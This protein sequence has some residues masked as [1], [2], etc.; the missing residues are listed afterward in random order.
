[1]ALSSTTCLNTYTGNGATSVYAYSF[2]IFDKTHLELVVYATDGTEYSPAVDTDY[3]VS[4]VDS[5]TGGNVTLVYT[6]QAYLN[7]DA[8]LKSGYVLVIRRVLPLKQETDI[9]NQGSY[10]PETHE[11]QFDRFTM[12]DQQQ[13]AEL[14]RTPKIPA[15]ETS[16]GALPSVTDRASKFAAYDSSGDPIA[17]DGGISGAIPVS[18]FMETVLDDTTATAARTTL[19]VPDGTDTYTNKT[20]SASSNSLQHIDSSRY[21]ANLGFATSVSSNALTVSLKGADGNAPSS[22]NKVFIGFRNST[23]TTGTY[24]VLSVSSALSVV[25]PSTTT[26]GTQNATATYIY[27]YALN[28]AGTVELGLSLSLFDEGAVQSSTAISGGSNAAVLYSTTA[29]TNVAIRL[30][31]RILITETTAGTWA[32][33]ATALAVAPFAIQPPQ[34]RFRSNGGQSVNGNATITWGA[35]DKVYDNWGMFTDA[36]DNWTVKMAGLYLISAYVRFGTGAQSIQIKYALNGSDSDIMAAATGNASN[37]TVLNFSE[38]IRLSVGD[39]ISIGAATG[40]SL[41]TSN[42]AFTMV[43]LSF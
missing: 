41:T 11:K 5:P 6:S 24:S 38:Q 19:G 31:G 4:G 3:T 40:G 20:I 13:Q 28:N 35:S 12:T 8:T 27:V 21:L 2:K 15:N 16:I 1:M 30:I 36:S 26:I 33:N 34:V 14:D 29:R 43:W 18:A 37:L 22:T 42:C 7:T 10:F 23:L 17:S 9:R 32:S 25:I 39:T